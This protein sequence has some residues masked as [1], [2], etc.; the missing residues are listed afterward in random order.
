MHI[1]REVKMRNLLFAFGHA[2]GGDASQTA[3]GCPVCLPNGFGWGQGGTL[4]RKDRQNI[5][6]DDAAIG[7]AAR[8][9]AQIK[10]VFMGQPPRDGRD[11]K[12]TRGAL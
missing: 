9:L 10:L 8:D 6:F 1:K 5:A 3:Q 2:P 11:V 12:P 7:G 4:G